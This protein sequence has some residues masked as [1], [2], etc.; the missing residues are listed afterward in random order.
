[1]REIVI[2]YCTCDQHHSDGG[3]SDK[4]KNDVEEIVL[5]SIEAPEDVKV[6]GVKVTDVKRIGGGFSIKLDA[7]GAY[8]KEKFSSELHFTVK[9]VPDEC[10]VCTLK[11]SG[12][13]EAVLQVRTGDDVPDFDQKFVCDVRKVRGGW[14]YYLTSGNYAT[15]TARELK[16]KGFNVKGSS[17]LYGKKDGKDVYR[18]YY[19]IKSPT[20]REGDF[21]GLDGRFY[22]IIESGKAVGVMDVGS[23]KKKKF[24]S[25]RLDKAS[26]AAAREDVA[27]GVVTA[28]SPKRIEALN[29]STFESATVS[30][31][32]KLKSGEEV[33]LVKLGKKFYATEAPEK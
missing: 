7:H 11:R 30:S 23:G 6:K 29:L 20:F 21:V 28:V 1:V 17:K 3:W 16:L 33:G 10:T 15:Q 4:V 27:K 13:Y 5:A 22:C 25:A 14:D 31:A 8:N 32:R 12:Y 18:L 26:L 2:P 9:T 24:S 19:S